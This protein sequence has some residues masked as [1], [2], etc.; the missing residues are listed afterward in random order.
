M[1]QITA[2]HKDLH[3][4]IRIRGKAQL[5]LQRQHATILMLD[6]KQA[7]SDAQT[8]ADKQLSQQTTHDYTCHCCNK[9]FPL[10]ITGMNYCP[11]CACDLCIY[12]DPQID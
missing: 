12:D 10:A 11:Y 9:S 8:E 5:L 4:L 2:E 1:K 7:L 6:L 3:V